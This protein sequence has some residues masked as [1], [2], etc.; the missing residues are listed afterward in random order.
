MIEK[1]DEFTSEIQ[2]SVK[3]IHISDEMEINPNLGDI[4]LVYWLS[5]K[6]V[7]YCQ[8]S[9]SGWMIGALYVLKEYHKS[10]YK[11]GSSLLQRAISCLKDA[12]ASYIK[13][14]VS[15]RDGDAIGFYEKY[16]FK[17]NGKSQNGFVNMVIIT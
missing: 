8:S 9:S 3:K 14:S 11:I 16:G 17:R 2:E 5:G 10:E 15:P 4:V 7:G 12:G 1:V 6:I 13:L